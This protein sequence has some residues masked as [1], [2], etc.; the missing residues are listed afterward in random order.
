LNRIGCCEEEDIG[1]TSAEVLDHPLGP[2]TVAEWLATEPRTDGDRL[3]LIWGYWHMTPAPSF[4]HQK[5]AHRLGRVLE[6]A[7]VAAGRGDLHMFCAAAVEIST[8]WRTGLI[9]DVVVLDFDPVGVSVAGEHV[10]LVA[11]VWSPGNS[12]AE[13]ETKV[14]AYAA[15]GVPYLWTVVLDE[16]RHASEVAAARLENGHYRIVD[17]AAPGQ[18]ALFT[19]APVPVSFDPAYLTGT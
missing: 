2:H 17:V 7:L 12:R 9:P 4:R 16:D 5:A 1:M 11:E 14:G 3:E 10:V 18:V 19:A 15:A 8:P 13:R 6:D